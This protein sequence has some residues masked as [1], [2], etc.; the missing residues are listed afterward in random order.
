MTNNFFFLVTKH[1]AMRPTKGN[2]QK[3]TIMNQPFSKKH[4]LLFTLFISL[5]VWGHVLWDYFHGGIPTHYLF[6][7]KDMPGIPN[8]VGAVV[9]PFFTWF[10]LGR[11]Q[12]RTNQPNTNETLQKIGLRFLAGLLFAITISICFLNDI[13]IVDYIMGTIFLL[14]FVFPLYRSEYLLGWVVGAAYTFGAIIPIGFGSLLCLFFFLFYFLVKWIKV[15][16]S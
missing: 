3:R 5:L 4:R 15:K 16:I 13:M 2:H 10:L 14:A 6:H 8:W 9:L 11:I 7:N 1:A 12:K